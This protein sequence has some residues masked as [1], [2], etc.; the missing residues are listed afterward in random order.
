VYALSGLY[1][2]DMSR[3]GL[4][5]YNNQIAKQSPRIRF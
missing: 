5:K 4:Q 1:V 2:L 3:G